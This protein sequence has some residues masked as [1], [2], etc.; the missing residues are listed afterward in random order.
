MTDPLA[1]PPLPD[2]ILDQIRAHRGRFVWLGWSLIALGAVAIVFPLVA[3]IAIK[4]LIGWVLLIAGAVTLWHAFQARSWGSALQS[5]LIGVLNLVVGV[6]LAFFPLTGLIG[7]TL[8][9]GI[10]FGVQGGAELAMALRHR[11]R[12]SWGWLAASGAI[13]MVLGLLLIL[14]LP[15]TALWAIGVMTG[16]NLISSGLSF[17]T[18]ARTV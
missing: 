6:Y 7:L 14:G 15:G 8:V 1:N 11:P 10:L 17:V 16:I 3:S 18:L 4:L 2:T 9:L 12:R 5:G 13:S